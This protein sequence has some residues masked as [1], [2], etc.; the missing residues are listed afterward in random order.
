MEMFLVNLRGPA[1]AVKT[2]DVEV[3]VCKKT[4]WAIDKK[5]RRHLVGSSIFQTLAAAERCR[6]ALLTTIVGSD[7]FRW[8]KPFNW[9]AAK[10]ALATLH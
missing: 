10:A 7:W 2:I 1:V 9:R 6:T 5:G 8:K 3:K 4:V